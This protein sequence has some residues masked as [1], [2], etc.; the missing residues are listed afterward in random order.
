MFQEQEKIIVVQQLHFINKLNENG[1]CNL[2]KKKTVILYY[3]ICSSL[4]FMKNI[5]TMK[6]L[7]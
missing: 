1:I 6:Y 4:Y 7:T 5:I 3:K 2:K